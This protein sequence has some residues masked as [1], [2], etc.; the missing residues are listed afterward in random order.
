MTTSSNQP[1]KTQSISS[2]SV[3]VPP[4]S[5]AGL[6]VARRY[7]VVADL[8]EP[9]AERRKNKPG[10]SAQCWRAKVMGAVQ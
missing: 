5:R 4:I 7:R 10:M 8:I 6:V 2:S 3:V 9:T 1:Q